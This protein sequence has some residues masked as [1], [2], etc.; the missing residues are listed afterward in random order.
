MNNSTLA[1]DLP[2]VPEAANSSAAQALWRTV[3]DELRKTLPQGEYQN[4]FEQITCCGIQENRLLLLANSD[5]AELWVNRNYQDLLA[6]QITLAAGRNMTF[7]LNAPAAVPAAPTVSGPLPAASPVPVLRRQETA[8]LPAAINADNTFENFIVAPENAMAHAASLA[9]ASDPGRVHNP[10]FIYG[11]T[12]LGKTHLLHAIAIA[13]MHRSPRAR[14]LYVT[15]EAFTNDYINAVTEKALPAFRRRYRETDV[16]LIDDIH[17]LADKE[18]TQEEFFHTFNDLHNYRKQI[19]LTSDRPAREIAKLEER[20]VSRFSWGM[21][22][23]IGAPRLETRIAILRKKA[24]S[25]GIE[26]DA[27]VILFLAERI[28][29]NVRNLEG[30]IHRLQ[31][32]QRVNSNGLAPITI[33]TAGRVLHDL[34]LEEVK[35]QITPEFIQTKVAEYYRLPQSDMKAEKRTAQVAF[36]RQVAMYLC[37]QITGMTRKAIA[38]AFCKKD[39][40]T[41]IHACKTVEAQMEVKPDTRRVVDYLT[42][43]ITNQRP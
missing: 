35:N 7:H 13:V 9:V 23:D 8:V 25:S 31:G 17:F 29:R 28:A 10:L 43:Q 37:A 30:A 11:A 42:A 12:G 26:L 32:Y 33:E 5:F 38:E 22:A 24:A 18:R 14:I 19:I 41:V 27:S 2:P 1:L 36:A 40:G 20:L 16:L 6:R 15:S 34:L 39:H 3:R 21:T 4:W